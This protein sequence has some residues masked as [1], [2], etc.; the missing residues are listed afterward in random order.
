MKSQTRRIAEVVIA[1]A[2]WI[3]SMFTLYWLEYGEIWT[4]ATPHR[5]KTSVAILIVGM[6]LSFLVHSA[7]AKRKQKK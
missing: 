7:F 3:L 5:G 2:P 1:F 4:T 6:S